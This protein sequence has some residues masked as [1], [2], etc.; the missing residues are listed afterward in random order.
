MKTK[1]QICALFQFDKRQAS[2][3]LKALLGSDFQFDKIKTV[4]HPKAINAIGQ[5]YLTLVKL[6]YNEENKTDREED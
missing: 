5:S 4:L 2:R 1:L 3:S 6:W